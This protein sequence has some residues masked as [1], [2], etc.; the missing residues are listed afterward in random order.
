[1]IVFEINTIN[2]LFENCSK[3][4]YGLEDDIEIIEDDDDVKTYESYSP[5]K[6][7]D[8]CASEIKF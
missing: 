2:R 1:M 7:C 5:F 4:E 8:K 3:H 6:L